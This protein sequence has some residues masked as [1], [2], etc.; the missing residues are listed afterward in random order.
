MSDRKMEQ[1]SSLYGNAD[2]VPDHCDEERVGLQGKA[3]SLLVY[4]LTLTYAH[5][6][7]VVNKRTRLKIQAA[8][9]WLLWRVAWFSL[10]DRL[11]SS[12]TGRKLGV[13]P[14]LLAVKRSQLRW[15]R[16]MIRM[17]LGCLPLEVLQACLPGQ[18]P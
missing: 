18:R 8:E 17:P 10:R 2:A 3:L 1:E 6:L 13:E 12:D 11:M 9:M 4:V 16:H 15:F 7:W 5:D 14:L